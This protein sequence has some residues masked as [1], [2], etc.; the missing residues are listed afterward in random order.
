MRRIGGGDSMEDERLHQ[1]LF[2]HMTNR[3]PTYRWGGLA[4]TFWGLLESD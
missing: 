1:M 3:G 2:N 4:M